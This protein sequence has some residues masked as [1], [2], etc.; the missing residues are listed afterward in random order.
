M[1]YCNSFATVEYCSIMSHNVPEYLLKYFD[2][3]SSLYSDE[4][5]RKLNASGACENRSMTTKKGPTKGSGGKHRNA[6]RGNCLLYTSPSPR[7]VEESRMP[8]SA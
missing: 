4:T 8:S 1:D 7:D 3:K 2:C 5:W 6:L